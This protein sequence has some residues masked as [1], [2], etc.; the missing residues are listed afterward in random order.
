MS[1][2]D[3]TFLDMRPDRGQDAALHD[4]LLHKERMFRKVALCITANLIY[5]E[6]AD[7][8]SG[9]RFPQS[10]A[11]ISWSANRCFQSLR[12]ENAETTNKEIKG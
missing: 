4:P 2:F 12:F 11:K 9:K 7:G 5:P 6:D 10:S 8:D 1:M 3:I